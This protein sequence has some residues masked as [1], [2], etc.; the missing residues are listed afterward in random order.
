MSEE[1]TCSIK[2]LNCGKWFKSDIH[3]GDTVSYNE[4]DTLG[5]KQQCPHCN[6]MTD[7]NKENMMF[8]SRDDAKVLHVEG[9]KTYR[10]NG[11][12]QS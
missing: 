9:E 5:N 10:K 12:E 7:C 11:S 4:T 2:C 1:V 3:L 6:Q 8:D